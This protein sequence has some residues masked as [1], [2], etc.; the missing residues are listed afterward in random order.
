MRLDFNETNILLQALSEL[1]R[2][3]QAPV[4]VARLLEFLDFL[5]TNTDT[6]YVFICDSVRSLT[7]KLEGLS[8]ESIGQ[9]LEDKSRN[10]II[11]TTCYT[12]PLV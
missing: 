7:K 1:G 3:S 4:T 9:I 11:A 5:L 12:L 2:V 8:D 6:G 10:K